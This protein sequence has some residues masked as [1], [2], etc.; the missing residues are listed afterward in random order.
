MSDWRTVLMWPGASTRSRGAPCAGVCG[1]CQW[2]GPID[3]KALEARALKPPFVPKVTD[4]F[5]VSNFDAE[6]RPR[7]LG[8][9]LGR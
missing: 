6:V 3:W 1:V 5:D 2:F 8:E 4:E 9:A 7:L